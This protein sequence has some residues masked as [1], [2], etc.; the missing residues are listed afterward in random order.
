MPKGRFS[1]TETAYARRHIQHAQ[2]Q[3]HEKSNRYR[4]IESVPCCTVRGLREALDKL[5]N[6]SQ[7]R[8]YLIDGDNDYITHV[9]LV[10]MT[11]SDGSIV[12][13]IRLV[14]KA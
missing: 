1:R 6:D 2:E 9:Q 8:T 10:E 11:L 13:D 7:H 4:V 14:R 5:V 12:T 3:A